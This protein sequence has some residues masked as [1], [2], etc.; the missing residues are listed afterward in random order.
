MYRYTRV[1][2]DGAISFECVCKPTWLGHVH[3][4]APN[5]IVSLTCVQRNPFLGF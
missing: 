5:S 2:V 4:L 1:N 3:L